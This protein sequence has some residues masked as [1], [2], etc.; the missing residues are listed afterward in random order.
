MVN[1]CQVDI[2][3][4]TI[5]PIF[6]FTR[7]GFYDKIKCTDEKS[8]RQGRSSMD[9]KNENEVR[10]L[11]NMG[12]IV[13]PMGLRRKLG[14]ETDDFVEIIDDYDRLIIRKYKPRCVF[15]GN[16]EEL[17]EYNGRF[18]CGRCVDVLSR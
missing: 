4:F 9:I 8:K 16:S 7:V 1:F 5:F 11:D 3:R 17:L 14:L 13:I 6:I 18:I 10:K 12:R 15:C 2:T